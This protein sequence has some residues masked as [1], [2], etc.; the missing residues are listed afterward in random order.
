MVIEIKM[1]GDKWRIGISESWEFEDMK[2][3]KESLEKLIQMKEKFGKIKN[4]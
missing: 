4:G 1:Y 3:F 2:S